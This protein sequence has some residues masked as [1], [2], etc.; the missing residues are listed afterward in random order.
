MKRKLI[1]DDIPEHYY[2]YIIFAT[3]KLW[4]I[5]NNGTL[6][7]I[8]IVGKKELLDYDE[9]EKGRLIYD[10]EFIDFLEDTVDEYCERYGVVYKAV[11]DNLKEDWRKE[12]EQSN[13]SN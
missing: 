3:Y 4:T 13:I 1:I 8:G 7:D 12:N 10:Y 11:V 5:N 2:N 9:K 6:N